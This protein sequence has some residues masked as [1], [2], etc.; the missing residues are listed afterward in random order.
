MLTITDGGSLT[1]ALST[2]IDPQLK[3]PLRDRVRQLECSLIIRSALQIAG[4]GITRLYRG[5]RPSKRHD[6]SRTERAASGRLTS[7]T[8]RDEDQLMEFKVAIKLCCPAFTAE[9][10]AR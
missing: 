5:D 7:K 9:D 8:R 10:F 1:R 6:G 2:S 4:E 3:Q